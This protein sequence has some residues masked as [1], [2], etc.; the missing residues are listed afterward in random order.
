[1]WIGGF[2]AGQQGGRIQPDLLLTFRFW[3]RWAYLVMSRFG[4]V[5]PIAAVVG[6]V[7]A[8]GRAR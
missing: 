2:L 7:F 3:K 1:L 4:V 8:R 5:L 6:V